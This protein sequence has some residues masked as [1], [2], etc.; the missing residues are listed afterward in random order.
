MRYEAVKTGGVIYSTSLAGKVMFVSKSVRRN[1]VIIFKS[2][3]KEDCNSSYCEQSET[4]F[5][6]YCPVF[7]NNRIF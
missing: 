1:T 4:F 7:K 5:V 2:F 6:F 3:S